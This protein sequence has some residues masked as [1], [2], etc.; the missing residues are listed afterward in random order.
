V[1]AADGEETEKKVQSQVLPAGR[2][3]SQNF[4]PERNGGRDS[5]ALELRNLEMGLGNQR[6]NGCWWSRE[7]Y[8]GGRC[9]EKCLR[10]K[11]WGKQITQEG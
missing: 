2:E 10:E 4:T 3:G 1:A 7:P 11:R 8:G 6:G 9:K 5:A